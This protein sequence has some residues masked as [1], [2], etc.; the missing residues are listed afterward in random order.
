MSGCYTRFIENDKRHGNVSINDL[1]KIRFTVN[2][3]LSCILTNL[4][5]KVNCKTS[6]SDRQQ[7]TGRKC[8]TLFS[9]VL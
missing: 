4:A 9:A 8:V 7:F 6:C 2:Y 1:S 3:C 5:Y